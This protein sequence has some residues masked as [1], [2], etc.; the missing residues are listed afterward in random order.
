MN[1][2]IYETLR[3]RVYRVMNYYAHGANTKIQI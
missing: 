1:P 3:E 2:L